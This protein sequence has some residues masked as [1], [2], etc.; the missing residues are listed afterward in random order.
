MATFQSDILLV[1]GASGTGKTSLINCGLTSRFQA[2]DWLTS[3]SGGGSDINLSRNRN[4]MKPLP[5]QRAPMAIWTRPRLDE[6]E[7]ATTGS[8]LSRQIQDIY[9]RYFALST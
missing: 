3:I 7:E 2:H 9:R 4:W 5:A 6:E 8:P 1:Y